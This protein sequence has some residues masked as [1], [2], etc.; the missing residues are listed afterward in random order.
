MSSQDK[1]A[2]WVEVRDSATGERNLSLYE[3]PIPCYQRERERYLNK[4]V[5]QLFPGAELRSYSGGV[6]T[7]VRDMLLI[8]AHYGAVR[9]GVSLTSFRARL[10]EPVATGPGQGLLFD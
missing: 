7:F 8:S 3:A 6:G 1:K 10:P 5:P 4:Q 2:L 9:E